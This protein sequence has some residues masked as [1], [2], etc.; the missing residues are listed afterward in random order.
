VNAEMYA[1]NQLRAQLAQAV[2][3]H[4]GLRDRVDTLEEL[5]GELL[6]EN[7]KATR[8]IKYWQD[9]YDLLIRERS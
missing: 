4:E 5:L 1:I 7:D 9:Q 8:Q 3:L 2:A 6:N